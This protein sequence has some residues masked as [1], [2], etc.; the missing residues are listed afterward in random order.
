MPPVSLTRETEADFT[1]RINA[2]TADSER[3]FGKMSVEQML[4][5]LRNA[6]EV[7]LGE[8]ELPDE[9]KPVIR[10]L[11]YFLICHVMTTWPGG[12][13][14]APDYWSPPADYEFEQERKELLDALHRFLDT[15]ESAPDRIGKHPILGPLSMEKWSRLMGVHIHHHMRQFGV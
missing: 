6:F 4:K 10:D 1:S 12:R 3:K 9:S 5:H 8:R 11:M 7:A 13:I 2:L 15:L 14:K